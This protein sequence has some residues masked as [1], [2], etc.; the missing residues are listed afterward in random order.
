MRALAGFGP[1]FGRAMYLLT[2]CCARVVLKRTQLFKDLKSKICEKSTRKN[3]NAKMTILAMYTPA[4]RDTIY[5]KRILVYEYICKRRRRTFLQ[6]IFL[7]KNRFLMA[8]E[9]GS[10]DAIRWNFKI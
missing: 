3:E 4:P 6:Y 10:T 7:R 2:L 5:G 9:K 1:K 8:N